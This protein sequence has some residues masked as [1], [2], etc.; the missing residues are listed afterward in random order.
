[1]RF[2]LLAISMVLLL[3]QGVAAQDA[4]LKIA[5]VGL[6]NPATL[7]KSNIGNALVD[8][9]DSEINQAG[10]Y[11]LLERAELGELKQ[12]L[13]L[14]S[15]EIADPKSFA[16][17]GG[18]TGA[19]FLLLGKVSDY[20]YKE[21]TFTKSEVIGAQ[22]QQVMYYEHVGDVRVDIRLVDVR[23]GEAVRSASGHGTARNT[24]Y[25]TFEAEWNRYV[26]SGGQATLSNLNTL[27]TDASHL[28]VSDAV[29]KL[30]DMYDDLA[31]FRSNRV[32]GAS[33]STIGSGRIL[34]DLG[35]GEYIIAVQSTSSLKL[36]DRFRVVTEVPIKNS[37]GVVV[38][39]EK[40][41]VGTL[42]VTDVSQRDK[43]KTRL[44]SGGSNVATNP[45][46][47]DTITF[48]E[49]YGK[50]LRGVAAG[51]PGVG[52]STTGAGATDPGRQ[53]NIH[54]YIEKGDRFMG[55]QEFSEALIQYRKGLQLS[56]N[57]AGLLARKS[58]AEEGVDAFTDAEDDAEKA[59]AAGGSISLPVAHNHSMGGYCKGT[60]VFEKGK[61][62]FQAEKGS[63]GFSVTSGSQIDATESRVSGSL[64][65]L[66]VRL[67]GPDNKDHKYEMV[68]TK[69]LMK[70]NR[71][72]QLFSVNTLTTTYS[73]EGAAETKTTHVDKMILRLIKK[74]LQ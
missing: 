10:K 66:L 37:K 41:D 73:A 67:L 22:I 20:T 60:L 43:A 25:A 49:E 36:G 46:E 11:T 15:S 71:P 34:A 44:V 45:K 31:A 57:D 18:L 68:V 27:L 9:L 24:G 32:V 63:H 21:N 19:D 2:R 69:Y 28:A 13:N 72:P 12:E 39:S 23:T 42:E 5:V 38:Y 55:E 70:V 48:D 30:N 62:T 65:G 8:I 29:R 4:R 51:S 74:S 16:Q 61:V 33:L 64:P 52:A 40:H 50:T 6:T 17:K 54:E 47:N 7:G 3:A 56:P 1:M 53:P 58:E 26:A 14:A 59:I 35:R